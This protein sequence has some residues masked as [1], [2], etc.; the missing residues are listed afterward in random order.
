MP[1]R[2]LTWH[3]ALIPTFLERRE[4]LCF[5]GVVPPEPRL[6]W[7]FLVFVGSFSFAS[8]ATWLLDVGPWAF[9]TAWVCTGALFIYSGIRS[10]AC[11]EADLAAAEHACGLLPP[12]QPLIRFADAYSVAAIAFSVGMAMLTALLLL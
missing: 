12:P 5:I 2:S 3:L 10:M 8:S 4:R 6:G 7:S 11:F 9:G 1:K